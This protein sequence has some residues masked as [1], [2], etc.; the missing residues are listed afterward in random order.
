MNANEIVAFFAEEVS[1]V[2]ESL[3]DSDKKLYHAILQSL[4]FN[5]LIEV[6]AG[7]SRR[8]NISW[9]LMDFIKWLKMHAKGNE[10]IETLLR[11]YGNKKSKKVSYA[12]RQLTK[13]YETQSFNNQ[14][15]ILRAFLSGGKYA[16]EWAATRLRKRWIPGLENKIKA[17]WGAHKGPIMAMTILYMMHED[18]VM[19]EQ[20]GLVRASHDPQSA[21]AILCGRLGGEPDF[22]IDESRLRI[23]DWFYVY[24]KLQRTDKVPEIDGKVDQFIRELD[25]KDFIM[26][27]EI[28][29]Y[30]FLPYL[31]MGRIIWAMRRMGYTEGLIRLA[32]MEQTAISLVKASGATDFQL[33]RTVYFLRSLVDD[34]LFN[35]DDYKRTVQ[36]WQ[37]LRTDLQTPPS[38]SELPLSLLEDD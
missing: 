17:A 38:L 4:P 5:I 32:K 12:F 21:Y 9:H 31:E 26:Y 33:A 28:S 25:C 11:W 36:S 20:E 18:F 35:E 27:E 37:D 22:V 15:R 30:S 10:P 13:R 7:L 3:Q 14:K 34:D 24:G 8:K 29:E 1:P 2:Y 16:S 6:E 23:I 19:Q